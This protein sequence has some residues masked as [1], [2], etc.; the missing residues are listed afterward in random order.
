M[1]IVERCLFPSL[2]FYWFDKHVPC[3]LLVLHGSAPQVKP[4][5]FCNHDYMSYFSQSAT[6][7]IRLYSRLSPDRIF[8]PTVHDV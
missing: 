5:T 1:S 6:T 8:S 7:R 3:D 2:S 4:F